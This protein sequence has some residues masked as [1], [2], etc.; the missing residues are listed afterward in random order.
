MEDSD[1]QDLHQLALRMRREMPCKERTVHLQNF[2]WTFSGQQ[3]ASYLLTH[4]FAQ[5]AHA[6]V[7]LCQRMLQQGLFKSIY[8]KDL[9]TADS[10]IYRFSSSMLDNKHKGLTG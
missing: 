9:F 4:G 2:K 6:A 5:D 10:E 1:S 8:H 3:A 7:E